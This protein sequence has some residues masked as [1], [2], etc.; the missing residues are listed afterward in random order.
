MH[1]GFMRIYLHQAPRLAMQVWQWKSSV[2][3]FQLNFEV[4]V[5]LAAT[6]ACA[7]PMGVKRFVSHICMA[8]RRAFFLDSEALQNPPGLC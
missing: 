3:R 2:F 7:D 8:P 6:F 4:F 5:I 1:V